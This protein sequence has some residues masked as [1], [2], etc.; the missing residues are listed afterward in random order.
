MTRESQERK[1]EILKDLTKWCFDPMGDLSNADALKDRTY[2]STEDY[3][4]RFAYFK[5]NRETEPEDD[6]IELEFE[7]YEEVKRAMINEI[8]QNPQDWKIYEKEKRKMAMVKHKSGRKHWI[9]KFHGISEGPWKGFGTGIREE[10]W[11]EIKN[12]INNPEKPGLPWNQ[13]IAEIQSK[14]DEGIPIESRELSD[15][16]H[17]KERINKCDTLDEINEVKKAVISDIEKIKD[18]KKNRDNDEENNNDPIEQFINNLTDEKEKTKAKE[19][20]RELITAE[21]LVKEN[22]FDSEILS[23]LLTEKENNTTAYQIINQEGRGDKIIGQLE[24]IQSSQSQNNNNSSS[25]NPNSDKDKN[26][27]TRIILFGS[28]F[29][30][31]VIVIWVVMTT[32]WKNKKF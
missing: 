30:A 26:S 25:K 3:W 1:K 13:V 20:L 11:E 12:A 27:L 17:W 10:E 21:N 18:K 6:S 14:L 28:L 22:Q 24:N 8:K 9:M 29:L 7:D 19:L 4:F 32:R 5:P 23:K 2:D 16:P 15:Y 31:V